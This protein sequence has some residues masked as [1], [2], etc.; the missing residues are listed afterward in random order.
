M[1]RRWTR[2]I[3]RVLVSVFA[4][5]ALATIP[6]GCCGSGKCGGCKHSA[7]CPPGCSQPCCKKAES[8]CHG[9]CGKPCCKKT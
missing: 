6:T 4:A 8:K 2:M 9:G 3:G 7:E 5:T 1:N